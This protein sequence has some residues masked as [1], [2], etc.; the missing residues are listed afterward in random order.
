MLK[1]SKVTGTSA[2]FSV[3]ARMPARAIA[4]SAKKFSAELGLNCC[5]NEVG[6][7]VFGN[8]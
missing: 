5:V 8:R 1:L 4:S 6:M 3:K 2:P 7:A